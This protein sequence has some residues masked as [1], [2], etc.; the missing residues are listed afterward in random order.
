[1]SKNFKFV[2]PILICVGISLF[3]YGKYVRPAPK[4][5]S[6][7]LAWGSDLKAAIA[8]AA[9]SGK[10]IMVDF[11]AVWCGPCQ[12]Y[13]E[14]VFDTQEFGDEARKFELV[15]VDV[16]Q[17]RAVAA[18]YGV[19][20]IPDIWFLNSKGQPLSHVIGYDGSDLVLDMRKAFD[21][22]K[23]PAPAKPLAKQA[24]NHCDS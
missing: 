24:A 16:D 4:K 20:P 3:V 15:D 10:P 11:N 6:V 8:K 14:H 17:D 19:D 5:S 13:K 2:I 12:E 18:S 7:H 22:A 1:M 9:V 23:Q 21:D